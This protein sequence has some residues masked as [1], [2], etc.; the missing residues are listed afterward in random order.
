MT[1]KI[2]QFKISLKE[3]DPLIWRR[4]LVPA[5]FSFWDLH[6]AIQDSMGWVDY[7]LHVFRIRRK[8]SHSD[9]EIGIPNED[10]FDDEQEILP[11]WEIP[12]SDYF[13]D[14]GVTFIYEYDFG[15]GWIHDVL[16]EGILLR[17]KGQKYPKC[18]DGA[19][20][21]PPEDCGGIHGYQELLKVISNPENDEYEEMMTW[22]GGKYDPAEFNPD[23]VKFDN[24]QKRWNTA[25]ADGL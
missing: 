13:D 17:E 3:I 21:C 23:Q 9:I 14:V 8:H 16:L 6:V 25:F 10:M 22:L 15:D 1:N 7:H 4:I 11:G 2:F 18:I 20:A 24:P 12:I 19:Q 5:T